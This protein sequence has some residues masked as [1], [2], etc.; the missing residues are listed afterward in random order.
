MK[1]HYSGFVFGLTL[2]FI[3]TLMWRFNAPDSTLKSA[4][5]FLF[6]TVFGI[7]ISIVCGIRLAKARAAS[8]SQAADEESKSQRAEIER[9]ISNHRSG[10]EENS[11]GESAIPSQYAIPQDDNY[12]T[13][14][15]AADSTPHRT[16]LERN[17]HV[18]MFASFV[19]VALKLFSTIWL[20]LFLRGSAADFAIVT[21]IGLFIFMIL[22]SLAMMPFS[23]N[24]K[25][26]F[27]IPKMLLVTTIAGI[28]ARI[29]F[30]RVR[31]DDAVA[32]DLEFLNYFVDSILFFYLLVMAGLGA[33]TVVIN[34]VSHRID[35]PELPFSKKR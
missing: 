6:G 22:I 28:G 24:A 9:L 19:I 11:N 27:G 18:L 20:R 33:I 10:V 7:V 1:N 30:Q 14:D 26:T 13:L 15:A 32:A 35:L 8:L 4:A 12:P 3:A 2:T 5:P 34:W 31:F 25:R 23:Y 21:L 29:Y 16:W 17:L